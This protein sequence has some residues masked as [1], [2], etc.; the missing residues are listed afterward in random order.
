VTELSVVL[1]NHNGAD[2][3]PSTLRA[4]AANTSAEEAEC[5]VVD[6]GSTDG[7]WQGVERLWDKARALRFEK[8]IGFC[9]G[10]NRGAEAARGRLLAFVNFDGE[11]EPD[12][13]GPLRELLNDPAVAIAT[14][15]L[16]TGDG[17]RVEAA[18]LEIAPNTATYGLEEGRPRTALPEGP[19]EV[20]AATG[21]LMM[22]RRSDFLA[23]G[24]FYEPIF[25]YG[26]ETDYC[27]RVD[28]R[29]VLHP[30]SAIRHEHGHAAGPPRSA[31]RL[32]WG[33]RNR[34][35]NAARHLP[36]PAL[37]KAVV[38]SAA[39]DVLTLVQVRRLDAARA[40]AGGWRD[41]VRMM[42]KERRTRSAAER[43]RSARRLGTLRE[44]L[45]QQRQLGRL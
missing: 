37:A 12:W 43:R 44:A 35:L 9:A 8:N 2:C 16:L 17:S 3:L 11:V 6:S 13:E 14:G 23:L 22:V 40:V 24:G 25:M 31:T 38:T 7:S 28:G 45:A 33:S 30:G 39:F 19:V 36:G 29:I 21:A 18:G 5:I 15:V 10:C 42:A 27:L 26:E 41:G 4:L 20:S 34:L 1:V 32:Y